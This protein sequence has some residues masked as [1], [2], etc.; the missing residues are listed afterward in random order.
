MPVR[1]DTIIIAPQTVA[2]L[3][4]RLPYDDLYRD[5]AA[6]ASG[7]SWML[8]GLFRGQGQTGSRCLSMTHRRNCKLLLFSN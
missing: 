4:N 3:G 8:K 7:G 5:P 6:A 2:S 1:E